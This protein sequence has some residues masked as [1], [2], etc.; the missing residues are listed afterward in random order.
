MAPRPRARPGGRAGGE[1]ARHGGDLAL[2]R[3]RRPRLAL[4]A[5]LLRRLRLPQARGGGRAGQPRHD[6]GEVPVPA[7]EPAAVDAPGRLPPEDAR[8]VLPHHQPGVGGEHH[9]RGRRRDGARRP[10]VR[11]LPG[12]GGAGGPAAAGGRGAVADDGG[13]HR[14]E[15]AA[16]AGQ[17]L[18]PP[19]LSGACPSSPSTG[20]TTRQVA[21]VVRG[22]EA[23]H[24]RPGNHRPGTG[25]RLYGQPGRDRHP[26]R[27]GPF[28][29]R[30]RPGGLDGLRAD[31]DRGGTRHRRGG[32]ERVRLREP[33]RPHGGPGSRLE[34][35]HDADGL[36]R[37][38]G[39]SRSAPGWSATTATASGR[40]CGERG[41]MRRRPCL[42]TCALST[43]TAGPAKSAGPTGS[44]G[45][46]GF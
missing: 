33:S 29:G 1:V 25:H 15:Y 38:S 12:R 31:G 40:G 23:G 20:K 13:A 37:P 24:R 22:P 32:A 14:R 4:P 28:R 27:L 34:R 10:Q 36:A 18:L 17:F 35:R 26:R 8:H 7:A 44:W 19:A 5:R 11:V 42:S 9:G 39:R 2:L 45:T 21:G 6:S 41:S 3:L 16:R 30:L 46:N 43:A